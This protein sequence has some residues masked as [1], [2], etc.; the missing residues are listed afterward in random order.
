M[1]EDCWL[2]NTDETEHEGEGAWEDML[3]QNVIAAWGYC[4][5]TG[6][7][8]TLN[9]PAAGETIFVTVQ[10]TGSSDGA[11]RPLRWATKTS[12]R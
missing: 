5:G 2:F 9:M 11:L 8:G 7:E 3:A 6:A 12:R 10:P 4:H 1:G